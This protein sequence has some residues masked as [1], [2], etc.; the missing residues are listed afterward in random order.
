MK[1]ISE[2]VNSI[3]YS[4]EEQPLCAVGPDTVTVRVALDSA[5]CDNVI[6]PKELPQDAEFEPDENDKH[7]K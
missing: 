7:F 5:A 2:S 6:D 3:E 1:S 4:E